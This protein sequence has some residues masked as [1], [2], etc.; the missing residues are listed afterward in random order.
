MGWAL[1]FQF[2]LGF[3]AQET[4]SK[5]LND[6]GSIPT[7]LLLNKDVKWVVCYKKP[8]RIRKG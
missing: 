6:Y 4:L 1:L 8:Y 7:I 5:L 3:F 2:R